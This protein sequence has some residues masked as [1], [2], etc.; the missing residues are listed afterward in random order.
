[1][2][3]THKY[4]GSLT[5]SMLVSFLSIHASLFERVRL[6]VQCR[7]VKDG[8]NECFNALGDENDGHEL[9]SNL[10]GTI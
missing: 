5:Q 8:G 10:R 9:Q 6:G 4:A 3:K 1:M 2:G 7:R